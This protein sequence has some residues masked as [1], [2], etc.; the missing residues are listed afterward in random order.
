AVTYT[1]APNYNGPDTFCF[2]VSDGSLLATGKVS[3]TVSPVNDTPIAGDQ[4]VTT[5]EDTSTNL[6]LVGSDVEGSVTFA[7]LVAPTN[8]A[9]S[10]F[11]PATGA[12]TYTPGP[13]YNGPDSFCFTV[14]DGSLTATGKVSITVSPI[15]DAPLANNQSVTTPEDTATNL[16]VTGSDVDNA[17]LTYAVLAGPSH[18]SLGAMN[19]ASGAVTYTPASNYAG[20][21]SF[22]FTV[23]DGSLLATGTVS[24]TVS[25]INDAPVANNQ[26]VTTPEDTATNLVVTGSDVD[27]ASL[28]YAVLAGPSHGS[29]GTMN[30]TSGAVTYTPA[31]DYNGP[32]SFTFTVSDGSLFATGAVSITV[33]PVNDRPVANDQ[34]VSTPQESPKNLVLTGSDVETGSLSFAILTNPARG[35]L[36]GLNA[37]SGAVTYTPAFDYIG[38]DSFTFTVSDGSL[39]ATGT[40]SITVTP[41]ADVA[42]FK[43]G[44][45]NATPNATLIY[46]ITV[47]NFGPSTATNIVVVDTL[48]TNAVFVSASAGGANSGGVVTWPTL[49]TLA[50]N[51]TTNFSVTVTVN[52][53]TNSLVVN[54]GSGSSSTPDPDPSNNTGTDPRS[55]V[56]TTVVPVQ[57]GL[58]QSANL[59]N[60]QTGLFEQ[61]VTV[62]NTGPSTVAAFQLLVGNINSTNGVP[63]TNV[64]LYNASGTNV[65]DSRPY[66]QY[67]SPLNPGSNVTLV[68]EF[69][70]PDR[71]PFTNSVEALAVLPAAAGTNAGPGVVIDRTFVDSRFSPARFVIEWTSVPGKTYTII[72]R[73]SL[74]S[75]WLVATPTVTAS[76]NRVQWYDDGPPKTVSPPFQ[77]V[78]RFYRVIANP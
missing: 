22:T 52:A 40:V 70:V 21:D 68:L 61:R 3:I 51:A 28:A 7:I 76:A 16:V 65:A 29:L 63:R 58:L 41:S 45:T 23:S 31:A 15:N 1:P 47:T 44:S 66:V 60:P 78:N 77:G 32:D 72:Y 9:L 24:I 57:F 2:T 56:T 17:S 50:R 38:P 5:P 14:S 64:S 69:Y 39:Q 37:S 35:G 55:R 49:A 42:V 25:P 36:S 12:V 20:P 26:S 62:T 53:P 73:D 18:G 30:P 54:V 33:S 71:K 11:N 59:F 13:N 67:N 27:S 10:L 6:V 74:D 75:P 43:T 19:S 46:T 34:S 8:G 4:T 48:P